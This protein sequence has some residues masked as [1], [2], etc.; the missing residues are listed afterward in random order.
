MY[1]DEPSMWITFCYTFFMPISH[2][3]VFSIPI[4]FSIL[5]LGAGCAS[6]PPISNP[7]AINNPPTI[8][9]TLAPASIADFIRERKTF[10]TFSEVE[11]R[12]RPAELEGMDGRNFVYVDNCTTR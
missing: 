5:L 1:E 9:D 3:H 6:N 7:T 8:Q 10:S 11:G 4:G 12:A 2:H